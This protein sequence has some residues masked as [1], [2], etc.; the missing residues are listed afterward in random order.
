MVLSL[1]LSGQEAR[2]AD[3]TA[4]WVLQ[5]GTLELAYG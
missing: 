4:G 3:A 5:D 1:I 2:E